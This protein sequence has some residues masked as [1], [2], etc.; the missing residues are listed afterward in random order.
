[1]IQRRIVIKKQHNDKCDQYLIKIGPL[2]SGLG[3]TI[4]NLLVNQIKSLKRYGVTQVKIMM[5]DKAVTNLETI[6]PIGN[7]LQSS[8]PVYDCLQKISN[9]VLNSNDPVVIDYDQDND[10][11]LNFK[12][13]PNSTSKI[14]I[15][16]QKIELITDIKLFNSPL[17]PDDSFNITTS[18]HQI[19]NIAYELQDAITKEKKDLIVLSIET[20]LYSEIDIVKL[21]NQSI[22]DLANKLL[23]YTINSIV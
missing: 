2:N 16:F 14:Q 19:L 13:N 1:M 8:L 20:N 21:I 5:D 12:K 15:I 6:L 17:N 3:H 18:A 23:T 22:E 9:L 7:Q 4:G 10:I 11:Y